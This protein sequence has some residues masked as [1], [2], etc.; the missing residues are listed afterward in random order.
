MKI[1]LRTI[2]KKKIKGGQSMLKEMAMTIIATTIS[3]ILTF[4]SSSIIEK[5]QKEMNRRQTVMMVIHDIENNIEQ[6]KGWKSG[7]EYQITLMHYVQNHLDEIELLPLDT[8]KEVYDY[9]LQDESGEDYKM[10]NYIES[11]F[12]ENQSLWSSLDDN[13]KI[14]DLVQEYFNDRH[15]QLVYWNNSSFFNYRISKQEQL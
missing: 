12:R 7:E 1:N 11:S 10:D 15:S 13:M 8:L 9:L 2:Q 14:I 3:I 6:V 5:R 4:G